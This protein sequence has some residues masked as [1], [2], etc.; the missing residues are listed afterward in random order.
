MRQEF[1]KT[2]HCDYGTSGG[3]WN[4][5]SVRWD[6]MRWFLPYVNRTEQHIKTFT[7]SAPSIHRAPTRR[8]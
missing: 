3:F 5:H 1:V 8:P 7:S 2:L 4:Y 6:R